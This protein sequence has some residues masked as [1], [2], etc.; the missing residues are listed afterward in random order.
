[1]ITNPILRGFHPDA[2][3]LAVGDDFYIATSTFEW[4]PG[5]CIYHS[6]DLANWS[7]VSVPVK[8]LDY[9][10]DESSGGLW[11]PHLSYADGKFWLVITDVRTRT[12]FKDTLNYVTTCETIDGV[13]SQP[14]FIN[15]S[16]FDPALFHDEDGKKY[17]LNMLWDYRP[18]HSGFAGMVLQEYDTAAGKLIGERRCIFEGT[19]LGV[20]EGPQILK[21]DGFYYLISAAGGTGYLHASVVARSKSVWGP[22]ELSPFHPLITTVGHPENPLQKSGHVSFLPVGNEWYLT[23]ICARPLTPMGNCVLGRETALQKVEWKNGWPTMVQGTSTPE[24]C[25]ENP[26]IAPCAVQKTNHSEK[27]DFDGDTWP[28]SF[29]SLR[30]PLGSTATTQQRRGFLRLYGR[31]CIMSTHAQ[32]LLA[33]RWQS[34]CFRAE[35]AMDFSPETFQ[36]MAGMALFYNTE[37]FFYLYKTAAMEGDGCT[38]NV[39]VATHG[40]LSF[41]AEAVSVPEGCL[42]FAAEVCGRHAQFFY[43]VHSADWQTIGPVLPA[44]HLSD[45]FIGQKHLVFTG[46]MIA[47]CCQ[48]LHD[49]TAFADF[50]YLDYKEYPDET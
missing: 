43:A 13:W 18:N 40:Q 36:Q 47:L 33:R 4:Y 11:A 45:D 42:R 41:A 50:D 28:L 2:S 16:G 31:E 39:L 19:D 27:E 30:I 12:A 15:A 49:H 46:A 26:Q 21:K 24:L 38:L 34:T 32:T 5:I 37:N 3:A 7:L 35:T 8:A 29:Q 44:D 17:F 48:D 6:N 10:G 20:A 9:V 25:V 14:Q 23:H 1:M 22:Y